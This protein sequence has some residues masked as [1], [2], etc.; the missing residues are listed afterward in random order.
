MTM[1]LVEVLVETFLVKSVEDPE[2][3]DRV[4]DDFFSNR[5]IDGNGIWTW[6]GRR[7]L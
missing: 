2:H 1:Y 3:E 7:V 5:K 6:R 4:G